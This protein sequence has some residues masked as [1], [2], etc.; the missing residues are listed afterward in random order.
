MLVKSNACTEEM[1]LM[2]TSSTSKSNVDVAKTQIEGWS[3][4][5]IPGAWSY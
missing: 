2:V 3:L 4:T 1:E 5:E